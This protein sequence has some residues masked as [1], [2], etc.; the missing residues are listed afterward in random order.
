MPV[1]GRGSENAGASGRDASMPIGS[2]ESGAPAS[3]VPASSA[4]GWPASGAGAPAWTPASRPS[5][6]T[7]SALLQAVSDR[8]SRQQEDGKA[9]RRSMN[10]VNS[11]FPSS[12]LPVSPN[13]SRLGQRANA[14]EMRAVRVFAGEAA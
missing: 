7:T 14:L 8:K 13:L 9:G 2:L 4:G 11:D 1:S 12:R 3:T 6:S 5:P 10:I